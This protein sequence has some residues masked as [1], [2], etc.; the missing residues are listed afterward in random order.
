MPLTRLIA[1]LLA[2]L[3]AAPVAAQQARQGPLQAVLQQHQAEVA[4]PSR[5]SVGEVL[6]ALDASDLPGVATFLERWQDRAVW[7]RD[8]DGLFFYAEPEGDAAIPCS[9]CR[10]RRPVGTRR[11]GRDL[12]DPPQWRR[13]AR[14]RLRAGALPALRPR[15]VA[16]PRRAD[17][18]RPLDR[19]RP[20]SSRCATPSKTSPT[21][22]SAP[23]RSGWRRC[24]PPASAP[25][26]EIR[27]EAIAA[28][29]GDLSVET[30]AV[31]NQLTA[32]R[33]GAGRG[34][35]A[36]RQHRPRAAPG[37][38]HHRGRRPTRF[39]SP[40][41]SRPSGCRRPRSSPR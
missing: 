14:D 9:I 3:L 11:R 29:G 30:R 31:L 19:T 39:S 34:P 21:R 20:S 38:R 10:P 13:P 35:A 22:R 4:E 26:T 36:G 24:S 33:R 37:R 15:P 18:D 25:T 8:S 27:I 32:T 16:P 2:W 12:R 40:R 7:V 1:G 5:R 28:L 17:R 41:A 23:A 6:D